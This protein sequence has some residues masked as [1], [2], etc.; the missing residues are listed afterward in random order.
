MAIPTYLR[1]DEFEDTRHN[2]DVDDSD[3]ALLRLYRPTLD[4]VVLAGRPHPN[5]KVCCVFCCCINLS[6][7]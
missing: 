6:I 1:G 3:E 4:A 2:A 5:L 7:H